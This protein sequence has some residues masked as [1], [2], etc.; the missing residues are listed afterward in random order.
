VDLLNVLRTLRR[1][2]WT[3]V[4]VAL[5]TLGAVGG[6][7]L[8]APK[9]Y[10]VAA[11][12]VLVSPSIPSDL[13]LT[14]HPELAAEN[15][16]NPY[17]RFSSQSIVGQVLATR[18]TSDEVRH[19]LVEQGVDK[20]YL[21][22]PSGDFGGA[23]QIVNVSGVGG[24]PQAAARATELIVTRMTSELRTLQRVYGAADRYLITLI[25]IEAPGEARLMVSGQL[26]SVI[27]VI[28]AG[29]LGLFAA[30][31]I[32]QAM[33]AERTPSPITRPRRLRPKGQRPTE[34]TVEN[35]VAPPILEEPASVG[36]RV[37]A[38]R[39]IRTGR[40]LSVADDHDAVSSTRQRDLEDD[41]EGDD[42]P[43]P[44]SVP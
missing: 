5:L 23:G 44:R 11:N 4:A 43:A 24:T 29:L 30:I 17:L 9:V 10:Q 12:Y 19:E 3:T 41:P 2:K 27:A 33:S 13:E 37:P 1:F 31:S 28:G 7:L 34:I 42:L 20:D 14:T 35:G 40:R 8:T 36:P 18:M 25:P 6:L 38:M 26:R 22:A 21:V 32:R 15:R 39:L 16:N